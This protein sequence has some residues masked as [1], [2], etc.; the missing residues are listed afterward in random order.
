MLRHKKG[1]RA[2][3]VLKNQKELAKQVCDRINEHGH[4]E[5]VEGGSK[6]PYSIDRGFGS[7]ICY[8]PEENLKLMLETEIKDWNNMSDVFEAWGHAGAYRFDPYVIID[9]NDEPVLV[10][11]HDRYL[12]ECR[13]RYFMVTKFIEGG[14]VCHTGTVNITFLWEGQEN[15]NSLLYYMLWWAALADV[16]MRFETGSKAVLSNTAELEKYIGEVV[17]R[18]GIEFEYTSADVFEHVQF[19][20]EPISFGKR[21][22]YRVVDAK[23]DLAYC[24]LRKKSIQIQTFKGTWTLTFHDSM[25][26]DP[27]MNC[28][29]YNAFLVLLMYI[30]D[31]R[32]SQT[33]AYPLRYRGD[34]QHVKFLDVPDAR[35][36]RNASDISNCLLDEI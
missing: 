14:Q 13:G 22:P 17:R 10:I 15:R 8:M 27:Y 32:V 16:V 24:A 19:N 9:E 35:V 34:F 31:I 2:V 4:L 3:C 5:Q 18:Y 11:R 6:L 25:E 7:Q 26:E 33:A 30:A 28:S 36:I 12:R 20:E 29:C 1:V 21:R 23:G